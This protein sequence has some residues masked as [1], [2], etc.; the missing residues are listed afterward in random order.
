MVKGTTTLFKLL[1]L[2]LF[3]EIKIRNILD[4]LPS[5]HSFQ[6]L[7]TTFEIEMRVAQEMVFLGITRGVIKTHTHPTK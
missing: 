1:L 4:Y 3:F 6:I 7:M 5:P 2:V